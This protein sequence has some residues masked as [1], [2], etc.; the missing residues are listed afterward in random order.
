[1]VVGRTLQ[2][3]IV[4]LLWILLASLS[5]AAQACG[6]NTK[7]R[8]GDRHYFV[9]MPTSHD[10]KTRVGAIIYAHGYRG[11]AKAVMGNKWFRQLGNRLGVA[12]IAPKSSG[13][14][15]S[16]PGSPSRMRGQPAIDELAYFDRLLDD[17]TARFA[18]DGK[19]IMVTGFSAGGMMVWTLACHRSNRFAA[20]APISGTFWRPVPVSCTTPPASIIHLHGD[21]DPI[22][23]LAGRRIGPTH[24][25]DVL[26]AIGMYAAYGDFS[27][28]IDKRRGRLRC[29][30][31][32]NAVGNILD[33]CLFSG[34]HTFSSGY[35]E[36]AWKLFA[37]AGRL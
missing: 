27:K 6:P 10:G 8:L 36:R 13:G 37:D 31:R 32:R 33:F 9:R 20:F 24:Q 12:F 21:R 22:V 26:K 23:P 29:K 35:I 7:C 25:G 19:R 5:S 17:V 15:W 16:L 4:C 3:G 2:N 14:D 11:T 30:S 28:P 1:M 34:G 18:I